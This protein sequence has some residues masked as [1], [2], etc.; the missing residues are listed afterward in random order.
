M[1]AF[2][3][4]TQISFSIPGLLKC[5]L[6]KTKHK[7]HFLYLHLIKRAL[8]FKVRKITKNTK[9]VK[10]LPNPSSPQKICFKN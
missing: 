1:L 7:F 6:S 9:R 10:I 5:W 4:K 2:E 8:H 3:D